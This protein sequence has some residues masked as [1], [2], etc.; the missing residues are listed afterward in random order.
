MKIEFLIEKVEKRQLPVPIGE[1]TFLKALCRE[2]L[3]RSIED[4]SMQSLLKLIEPQIFSIQEG[5]RSGSTKKS[6]YHLDS[7]ELV[8]S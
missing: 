7:T 3:R 1:E 6:L 4:T 8:R 5:H 2:G